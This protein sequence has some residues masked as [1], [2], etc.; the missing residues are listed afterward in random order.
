MSLMNNTQDHTH[1]HPHQ[2]QTVRVFWNKTGIS[3]TSDN[4]IFA[5]FLSGHFLRNG[6]THPKKSERGAHKKTHPER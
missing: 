3:Y 1:D 6:V 2:Q 5:N 4:E